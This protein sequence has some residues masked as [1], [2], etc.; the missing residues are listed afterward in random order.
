M[1]INEEMT[2]KKLTAICLLKKTSDY[3]RILILIDAKHEILAVTVNYITV[4]VV[5]TQLCYSP[6]YLLCVFCSVL[7]FTIVLYA[8]TPVCFVQ[9]M[10]RLILIFLGIYSK[11]IP[12][13]CLTI[14]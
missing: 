1:T 8:S 4:R 7:V 13:M 11:Q 3:D 9:C 10:Q 2:G 14:T 6:L 5:S 12:Y